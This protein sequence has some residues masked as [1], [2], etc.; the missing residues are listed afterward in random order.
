LVASSGHVN[1]RLL[2]ME[3]EAWKLEDVRIE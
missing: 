1:L 3:L 2:N